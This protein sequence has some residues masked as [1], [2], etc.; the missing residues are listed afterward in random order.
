[1]NKLKE[2]I[3][4]DYIVNVNDY[5]KELIKKG[6]LKTPDNEILKLN[7]FDMEFES[8]KMESM[9]DLI[10]DNVANLW[11]IPPETQNEIISD[12]IIGLLPVADIS[13]C[14]NYI[15]YQILND[16][17]RK[18][19]ELDNEVK[20]LIK[21]N[22]KRH[23]K[24]FKGGVNAPEYQAQALINENVF[25]NESNKK[26]YIF[27]GKAKKFNELSVDNIMQILL[28]YYPNLSA[29]KYDVMGYMKVSYIFFITKS[30]L[31][32]VYNNNKSYLI[33]LDKIKADYD[34]LNGI[35]SKFR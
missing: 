23:K 32:I 13:E 30:T 28:K 10:D 18:P 3:L 33:E 24:V 26:Y 8:V 5:V 14:N 16:K 35:V 11:N 7:V 25:Y 17:V 29:S 1:M 6:Y 2:T 34:K 21:S 31:P 9:I 19:K 20:A 15:R 22:E 4:K 12:I 27:D